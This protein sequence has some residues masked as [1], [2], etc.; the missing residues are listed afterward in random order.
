MAVS[1]S[2]GPV[3]GSR[4]ELLADARVRASV[5]VRDAAKTVRELGFEP[6][7]NGT[8]ANRK[9]GKAA[10]RKS[11]NGKAPNEGGPRPVREHDLDNKRVRATCAL[12]QGQGRGPTIV[13]RRTICPF[14]RAHNHRDIMMA[15]VS[16][17]SG[18]RRM[19]PILQRPIDAEPRCYPEALLRTVRIFLRNPTDD[20][21]ELLRMVGEVGPDSQTELQAEYAAR[22][23]AE[24]GTNLFGGNM[25]S[26]VH[27]ALARGGGEYV[28][29]KTSRLKKRGE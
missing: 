14:D 17:A 11:A 22:V 6:P 13:M 25:A 26:M 23:A 12:P 28:K 7:K 1:N 10:N 15:L 8:A 21:E 24:T 9:S 19:R 16:A 29:K 18:G 27:A 2:G 20:G 4:A 3:N 5:A